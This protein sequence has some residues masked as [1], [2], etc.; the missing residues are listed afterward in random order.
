M[1]PEILWVGLFLVVGLACFDWRRAVKAALVLLVIEGAIR[2]WVLP[3]A[4]DTIYFLKDFVLLG[5]YAGYLLDRD[6]E[7][8]RG[9]G[10]MRVIL[11]VSATFVVLQ[12]FNMR[13]NSL[14]V[15]I[16]GM[17][18]Y[19]FYVPLCFMLKSMFR[20]SNELE[21][22]LRR[23]LLLAAPVCLLGFVQFLSPPS[24]VLNIYATG[25]AVPISTFGVHGNP[26]ITGTF[27]YISGHGIYVFISLVFAIV[28]LRVRQSGIW[29]VLLVSVAVLIVGNTFMTG[30][31]GPVLAE[32]LFL[33]G[34]LWLSGA[35]SVSQTRSS[36]APILVAGV[37]CLAASI[38]WFDDAISAFFERATT[39]DSL[40]ERIADSY[41]EPLRVLY[42]EDMFGFG[43]ASSHPGGA[44]LRNRFNLSDAD[45]APPPA[46]LEP[47]RVFFELGLVG[48]LAWYA[49]R[50]YLL[51]TLWRTSKVVSS[52]LL[53]NLA[54]AAFLIHAIQ[55][56]GSLVLNQTFAIYYW[57]TAGF[58]FLL[59]K[60]EVLLQ[61]QETQP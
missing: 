13:M 38:Y 35:A 25:D 15:G 44:A 9:M 30:S 45:I 47:V 40:T 21:T 4:S 1:S 56:S 33:I 36:F 16:F 43:T 14:V 20:S 59:P 57:L 42:E 23:Y 39:S 53:R 8:T 11:A 48:F 26:R 46:E 61:F 31:R 37:L 17:K 28:L 50:S 41:R 7:P 18:V 52:P 12:A 6:R 60:L 49:L 2:K 34:F 22:W 27:S 3:G 55:L 51:W 5:A 58:I 10:H 32:G 54:L 29:R 19:L 24:S